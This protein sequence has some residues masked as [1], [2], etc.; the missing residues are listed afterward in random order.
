MVIHVEENPN[1]SIA[2]HWIPSNSKKTHTTESCSNLGSFLYVSV[3]RVSSHAL[4]KTETLT[5]EDTSYKKHCT[6]DNDAS[7]PF[8]V[9]AFGTSHNSTSISFTVQNTLQNPLLE[10]PSAAPSYFP[11][12]RNQFCHNTFH[13][14]ILLQNLRHSSFWNPQIS[15]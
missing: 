14:K 7:V 2:T 3:Q 10:S 15:F 1:C 11:E 5:E 9:G 4:W 12:S 8:K 6:Q 13:A